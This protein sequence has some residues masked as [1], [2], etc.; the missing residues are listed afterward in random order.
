MV[1]HV[2]G[3]SFADTLNVI[4]G[5]QDAATASKF[6]SPYAAINACTFTQKTCT[7][8]T[9]T[10]TATAG[11]VKVTENSP[12]N[13]KPQQIQCTLV[14]RCDQDKVCSSVCREGTVEIAPWVARAIAH[15]RN[16]A[17]EHPLCFTQ[18]P[19]THN[20]GTTLARGWG[21]R[22]QL[23]NK[24]LDPANAGSFMRTDNQ[25][26][27]VTDQLNLGA[28][29]VEMDVHYFGKTIRD[30]HCSNVNFDLLQ[31]VG[32]ALVRTTQALLDV[33]A[34]EWQPSLMG[35]L[36]SLGGIKAANT[37]AHA[38]TVKEITAW[39]QAN[40]NDL[41][42]VYLD[43]G[44]EVKTFDKYDE[45]LALYTA[46]FG[47]LLFSPAD[48][49]KAGGSWKSFTLSSLVEQGKRVVVVANEGS[50]VAFEMKKLC[51]G[52]SNVPGGKTGGGA[53]TIWGKK[54]NTGALVRAYTSVLHYATM[55]EDEVD[56]ST[57]VGTAFE[58]ATVEASTLPAFVNAGVNILAPDGLDGAVM[59]GMVWSWAAKEPSRGDTAV[60]IS[61]KDGRWYGVADASNLQNVACVSTSNRLSWQIVSQGS[62]CPSGFV[63][64]APKLAVENVALTTALRTT[65]AEATAQLEVD[66]TT[67]PVISAE[68]EAAFDDVTNRGGSPGPASSN[69]VDQLSTSVLAGL[70]AALAVVA[71]H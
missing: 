23:M 3:D 16:L 28:R 2:T 6:V 45:M 46:A 37:R 56:D 20:T 22:D 67:F 38:D 53:G 55:A 15:Q 27:T 54:A 17:Y 58:P 65:G 29:F 59:Q 34:V 19:G 39:V 32:A 62:S 8:P 60:E 9:F 26:F 48:L 13:A 52:F 69:D 66:L 61:A 40:P 30:G 24:V 35:C 33:E 1:T 11:R 21:N 44:S 70:V 68:E 36:P 47:D 7:K 14:E 71:M 25:F 50:E 41:V 4:A 57:I 18:L 12:K 42:I 5:L 43:V 31:D 63:A 49:A 64:G 51:D 10:L